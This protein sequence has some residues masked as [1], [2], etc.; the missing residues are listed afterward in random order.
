MLNITFWQHLSFIPDHTHATLGKIPLIATGSYLIFGLLF[1]W[2]AMAKSA[3]PFSLKGALK[4][5]FPAHLYTH[6]SSKLDLFLL[7]FTVGLPMA[8]TALGYTALLWTGESVRA[9]LQ[10]FSGP[11][12]LSISNPVVAIALQFA[13]V[14]LAM[15]F[16]NF[17]YHYLFHK[18]PF[19]WR[20]HRV[21][22]S[23][24]VL[25]PLTRWRF[26]PA[27]VVFEL[28]FKGPFA[29]VISGS[30]LHLF[31]MNV[32]VE[33]TTLVAAMSIAFEASFF[34]RH[35]HVWVSYGP[36]AS[37]ILCSPCMHHV[38]H[39]IDPRHWDKNFGLMLSIWDYLFDSRYV[40]Q[41]RE[42]LRFGIN[43]DEIG[44]RNPHATVSGALI[45]PVM[46]AMPKRLTA[47]AGEP[48]Y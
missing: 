37:R 26:H 38:H 40:P 13:T 22:H 10:E 33:A 42:E 14:F 4:H 17:M 16:A 9:W 8:V 28:S 19:L 3:E 1:S 43:V 27:E 7:P 46:S 41:E 35:S 39:S 32:G 11:T 45:E 5:L 18:I 31:G 24:E 47:G 15:D 21:H 20:F 23:A 48:T 29:G 12:A 2:W 34:F 44:A 30:V 25:T 6:S 36:V